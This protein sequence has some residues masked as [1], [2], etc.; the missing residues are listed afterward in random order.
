MFGKLRLLNCCLYLHCKCC[1]NITVIYL[2]K[3]KRPSFHSTLYCSLYLHC[4]FCKNYSILPVKI[5]T[6]CFITVLSFVTRDYSFL[7]VKYYSSCCCKKT[8]IF[9][10]VL[11]LVLRI[12][13]RCDPLENY[14][15]AWLKSILFDV[16]DSKYEFEKYGR[17]EYRGVVTLSREA[18]RAA[19]Q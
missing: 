14:S 4:K 15:L 18:L 6:N 17:E 9:N 3:Y 2:L 11:T 10:S 5:Q 1:K 13:L 19:I 12:D 7:T 8:F 16:K